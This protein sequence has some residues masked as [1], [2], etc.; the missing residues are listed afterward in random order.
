[1]N[2]GDLA[3]RPELGISILV[4][5]ENALERQ[6]TGV[7]ITDLPDPSRFLSV[8]DVVLTSG[9]WV[10]RPGGMEKFVN[11]L[12]RQRVA[13]L[14]VGI[15]EIGSIP[16]ELIALCR[17]HQLTLATIAETVSF[18][19]L[20]EE[21]AKGQP[22]STNG[23]LARGIRFNRQLSDV[24][25]R[26]GGAAAALQ[27][28]HDEFAI[29]CWVID[30]VGSVIATA[31]AEPTRVHV[32]AV[33]NQMM[34][35]TGAEITLVP[36]ADDRPFSVWAIGTGQ[37]RA[38][39]HLVCWGDYRT[40]SPEVSIVVSALLGALRVEL[41]LSSRWRDS[42]HSHV[43]E[44]VQLLIDDTVSPG[45]ISARMRLEGLDPQLA[46][47]IVI[48][49]VDDP[50]FPP[51]AVLE[52]A[53][54]MFS[55]QSSHVIGGI[56]DGRAVLLVSGAGQDGESYEDGVIRLAE[57]YLPFLAGRQL[58]M[59]LSDPIMGV[60]QLGS[61]I[62]VARER[63]ANL[64]GSGPVLL[65]NTS[66]VQSH[67]DLLMML[68]ERTR[69]AYASEVLRP[70]I[71][72]DTKNGGDLVG[73]LRAFLESGGAWVESARQLHMHP[74]T[75]RYRIGRIEMLTNRDLSSMEDRVDMY[76]AL[77]SLGPVG[78]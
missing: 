31:G 71:A 27:L 10:S 3:R 73:T 58:R 9:L 32:A 22:G 56:M 48:A 35:A 67:R 45:E 30:T 37:D 49:E 15:I 19:T 14:I 39:G 65:S 51:S 70:L 40:F 13:A 74:N 60:S 61:G 77:A 78:P 59:G 44:L 63:L 52:M 33:W 53:Y 47:S 42:H 38:A 50:R 1:M 24:L 57:D 20:S 29:S 41:E 5:G 4:P 26:G 62:A 76:L 17:Q 12:A 21:V 36:D 23:L 16:D 11:A 75:L 28:F 54:R 69:S 68:G 55:T 25:G 7:Y 46:T 72:Y 8:G 2:F 64:S 34:N 18:K 6:V 43:S 66:S